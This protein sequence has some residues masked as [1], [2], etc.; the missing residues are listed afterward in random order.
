MSDA[1][2][3]PGWWTCEGCNGDVRPSDAHKK[4]VPG[5]EGDILLAFCERCWHDE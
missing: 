3:D 4:T 5:T 1:Q 2:P